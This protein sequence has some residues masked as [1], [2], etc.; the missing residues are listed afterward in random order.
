[1][2]ENQ[3]KPCVIKKSVSDKVYERNVWIIII[4]ILVAVIGLVLIII[5]E[6]LS[7]YVVGTIILV[8]GIYFVLR[9]FGIG[10]KKKEV[11]E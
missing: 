8:P 2:S 6:Y 4:T 5:G 3:K 9:A 1:M 10:I 7:Y 11:C